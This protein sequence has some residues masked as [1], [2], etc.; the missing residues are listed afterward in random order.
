V[1][2]AC[3]AGAIERTKRSPQSPSSA[4]Q[5][6]AAQFLERCSTR[7]PPTGGRVLVRPVAAVYTSGPTIGSEHGS[8]LPRSSG[9][10]SWR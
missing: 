7:G 5:P 6:S 8:V 9:P 2:S 4:P 3:G 1:R 10:S